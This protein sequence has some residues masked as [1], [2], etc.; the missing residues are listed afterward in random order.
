MTPTY[1]TFTTLDGIDIDTFIRASIPYMDA[2]TYDWPPQCVD[3]ASK[4]AFL[5]GYIDELIGLSNTYSYYMTIDGYM[6]SVMFCQKFGTTL[7]TLLTFVRPDKNGSRA[8]NYRPK[9]FAAWKQFLA[10]EGFD[11]M[12]GLVTRDSPLKKLMAVD[13]VTEYEDKQV[14]GGVTPT[15]TYK[16]R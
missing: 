10:S 12:E 6:V 11:Q 16:V 1:Q 15:F 3:E 8:F 14:G 2:G 13:G 4:I 5:R 7:R 9:T